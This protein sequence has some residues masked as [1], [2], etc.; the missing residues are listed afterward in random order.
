MSVVYPI[1]RAQ[2]LSAH[3]I[4]NTGLK[5]AVEPLTLF[6]IASHNSVQCC[7]LQQAY[8]VNQ[9]QAVA[10]VIPSAASVVS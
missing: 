1:L 4:I 5:V 6:T 10:E 9:S 3:N 7:V 8:N 2:P